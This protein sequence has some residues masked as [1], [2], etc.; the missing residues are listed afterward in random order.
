[1][2]W[3]TGQ[4][5]FGQRSLFHVTF[6]RSAVPAPQNRTEHINGL[7]SPNGWYLQK[8]KP[9]GGTILEASNLRTTGRLK[10]LAH[11]RDGSA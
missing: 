2:V 6:H 4:N 5:H 7:P 11:C 10:R 3:T 1:M 8:E 9:M